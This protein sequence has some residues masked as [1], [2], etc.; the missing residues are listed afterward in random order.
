M[1]L[2]K[3]GASVE[4]FL[5]LSNQLFDVEL[6]PMR[7]GAVSLRR[8][9][10]VFDTN[11]LRSEDAALFGNLIIR[12]TTEGECALRT[13]S[14]G[15]LAA[16]Y[17]VSKDEIRLI[18]GDDA[19]EVEECWRLEG[20]ELKWDFSIANK[21]ACAVRIGDIE[22]PLA[23]NQAYAKDTI[24]TYTQRLVRHGHCALDGSFFY[25]CRP[26]GVGPMLTMVPGVGTAL[27]YFKRD[28]ESQSSGWEGSY[29]VFIR[30]EIAG[31]GAPWKYPHTGETLEAGQRRAFSFRFG[32][33]KDLEDVRNRLVLMGS[34][35]M[36]V[37]P[38]M[39]VTPQMPVRLALRSQESIDEW[40]APE[41]AAVR[42]M[43][44]KNGYRLYELSFGK[45]GENP[46]EICFGGSR[47]TRLDF[48]V[49]KPIDQLLKAR[50]R[51]MVK[52]QQ[53]RGEKWYDGL[54]SQWDMQTKQLATPDN[55]L[56]LPAYIT[57]G[58]DDPGLC[59]A[60]FIAA[61]NM[62]YPVDEEIEA[63]EYY[64][65]HFL[66]GGQQRTDGEQ[67]RPY[68]IYGSD[69]WYVQRNCGTGFDCGGVGEDRMWRTFDYPHIA[70][71][72]YYMYRIARCYPE[73]VHYLDAA[74]YLERAY[75]TAMAFYTIPIS[76]FMREPWDFHGWCDWAYKQGNFGELVIPWI[77]DALEA[78]GRLEDAGKLRREWETKVRYMVYDHP[79]PF[80]SEMWFDTTA[81][82]STH[83]VA[84]YGLEHGV[85]PDPEG[86]FDR[87]ALGPGQGKR[88]QPHP[89]IRREDFERFMERELIANKAARG[90][91]EPS[92]E[93]MGSD[94]RQ[95]GNSNYALSYMTHMGGWSLLDAAIYDSERPE[96]DIRVAYASYLAGWMLVHTG[97]D[98]P[99]FACKENEGA[100]AWA[101]EPSSHGT[102]WIG[103][104]F[105]CPRGPWRFDGEIDCGFTGGIR[106]AA[107]VLVED[108]LFGPYLY[109][110]TVRRTEEGLL[111]RPMDGLNQ[112]LHILM[113]GEKMH[114]LLD[115]DGI[116]EALVREDSLDL[117][118]ENRTGDAHELSINLKNKGVLKISVPAEKLFRVTIPRE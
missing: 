88:L 37:L 34:L 58:A 43:G 21:Q 7:N 79:Y 70:Q 55:R 9:N 117:T 57:G 50:A 78:E 13:L 116:V 46:V 63:V 106:S 25:W 12:Y 113:G 15:M 51:H 4:S 54:F 6:D 100:A 48:F 80:G 2:L 41:G 102:P 108:P 114:I 104:E 92:Y 36:L 68:G 62:V 5:K 103:R 44:E 39:T 11:Y 115:R 59:K 65:E 40:I 76:I 18:C 29:S 49:T 111:L 93:L 38:G 112:R 98:Y 33:A 19:L 1:R 91:I 97:E 67:P 105:D 35:D 23:F 94:I 45:I 53:Y 77:I 66:W 61:K 75:R 87:N 83:A 10:D 72:Y 81:F 31:E 27:E 17:V 16:N 74:G 89:E 24:V 56:G 28:R 110:G 109:G 86:Y 32:W 26:N 73:K 8:V 82:E 14:T 22:L 107:S 99:W 30:S 90:L 84:K 69:F 47:R 71:L 96:E 101:F 42:E 3:G 20:D 60:P 95:H 52:Y 85:A 118:L 64:I